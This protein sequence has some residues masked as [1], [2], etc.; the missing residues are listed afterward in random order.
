MKTLIAFGKIIFGVILLIL[1]ITFFLPSKIHV[2]RTA[3]IKS[4]PETAFTLINNL[5]EW[6]RWSPWHRK[7][8]NMKVT[9]GPTK[10]GKGSFYEWTSDHDQV[11]NGKMT[12]ADTKPVEYIK[13]EMNFME[14]GTATGEFFL[15]P[16]EGGT[17]IKWTMDSDMGANP[18]HKIM[19]LFMD[20]WVGGDYEHGLHFLDSVSQLQRPTVSKMDLEMGRVDAMKLIL[21]KG[22][23]TE[24]EIQKT[25]DGIFAR[26]RELA[27]KESLSISGVPV[28]FYEEPAKGTYLFEAGFPINSKP[29]KA[30]PADIMYKETPASEAAI[31][32]FSGDPKITPEAYQKLLGFIK[33]KGKTMAASPMEKY[34]SD[35]NDQSPDMVIDIIWPVQ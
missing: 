18:I 17:E 33:E 7:D 3:I 30:V 9:Y 23:A 25:L 8:P 20:K 34:L 4:T 16:V 12:I 1:V 27:V 31:C 10:Q 5:E 29:A 11:G 15:R 24:G 22:K 21:I 2:E 19:G 32:H 26:L 13:T 35:G 28:A 6:Y 14:N